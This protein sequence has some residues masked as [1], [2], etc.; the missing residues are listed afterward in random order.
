MQLN[1]FGLAKGMTST[2]YPRSTFFKLYVALLA[3]TTADSLGKGCPES[4]S[5]NSSG[6]TLLQRKIP[7]ATTFQE[8]SFYFHQ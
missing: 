2:G 3:A 5:R 4:W 1:T 6:W 7:E 8:F